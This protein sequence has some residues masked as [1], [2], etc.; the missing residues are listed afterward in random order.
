MTV[1]TGLQV[2]L[3][4][5]LAALAGQRVG[6]VTNP[7]G[8]LP[9]FSS[10]VD[11]LLDAGVRITALFGPE[12][13]VRASAPDGKPVASDHDG[14]T[15]LPV[16]S[17]Y[18]T[19]KRP[20][21]AMTG[22]VDTFLYD[23]QD[24]GARF[25]TYIWTLSHVMEAAKEMGKRVV[26]LDRPNPLGGLRME[27]GLLDERFESL[28]GRWPI[29]LRYSLTIGELAKWFNLRVSCDLTVVPMEGW[30][31]HMW[32]DETGLPWV[33]PS[34]GMPTID[35]ATVY[36][37]ACLF[38]GTTMSEGRGTTMPFLWTGAPW[39]DGDLWARNL[40]RLGL[41]G[42]R[43]RA[44]AFTPT[45]SKH[46]G[47]ECFGVQTHVTDRDAYLPVRTALHMLLTARRLAPVEFNWLPSSWEGHPP[48]VDLLAGGPTV[49]EM[50]NAGCTVADI[51]ATWHAGLAAFTAQAE[52][53]CLY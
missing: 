37:G 26:V 2:L 5:D 41:P 22:N 8:V 33:P 29:P 1:R 38:E 20:T 14:R 9:D 15:S 3:S 47:L 12:H 36:P 23:I 6:L 51:E 49:R 40:N 39:I 16:F 48:H 46:E 53:C 32:Y 11:V 50:L 21:A 10:N 19:D 42:V 28:V 7:T 17:L 35:V 52:Q 34:P 44:V 30:Q 24:V 27:G 13:G 25:Y 18:G 45:T 4:G 31:R 43:F